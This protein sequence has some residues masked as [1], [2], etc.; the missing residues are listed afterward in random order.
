MP[1]TCVPLILLVALKND[2]TIRCAVLDVLRR[3]MSETRMSWTGAL[4]HSPVPLVP[5]SSG[6]GHWGAVEAACREFLRSA[7]VE[8]NDARWVMKHFGDNTH[9]LMAMVGAVGECQ[10]HFPELVHTVR[11]WQSVMDKAAFI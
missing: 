10:L 4:L 2:L 8:M 1:H 9:G 11:P 6:A 7:T 3:E 5:K